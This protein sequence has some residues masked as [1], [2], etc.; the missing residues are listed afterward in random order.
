MITNFLL[1]TIFF[2]LNGLILLLPDGAT[3]PAIVT[4]AF[5]YVFSAFGKIPFLP[6]AVQLSTL[7]TAAFYFSIGILLWYLFGWLLKKIPGV[8]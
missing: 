4:T 8:S 6:T 3:L 5:T 2:I 7:L 1:Y